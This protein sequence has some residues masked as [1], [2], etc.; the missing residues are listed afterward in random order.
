MLPELL[1]PI[2]LHYSQ[3]GSALDWASE[4][5]VVYF[6]SVARPVV[7][8]MQF[9]IEASFEICKRCYLRA[10]KTIG[11]RQLVIANERAQAGVAQSRALSQQRKLWAMIWWRM[12]GWDEI[13]D[14]N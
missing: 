3:I 13:A 14:R 8:I 10:M 1:A 5:L 4:Q 12:D 9:I 7:I 6:L 2:S 11:G